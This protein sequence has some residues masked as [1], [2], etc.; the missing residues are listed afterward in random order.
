MS[1]RKLFPPFKWNSY[2]GLFQYPTLPACARRAT[3]SSL[4]PPQNPYVGYFN[5]SLKMTTPIDNFIYV[6]CTA[7]KGTQTEVDQAMAIGDKIIASYKV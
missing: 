5:A 7:E 1:E 3:P 4:L 2:V 6:T